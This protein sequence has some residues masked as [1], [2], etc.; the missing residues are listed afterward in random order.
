MNILF[1]KY[2]FLR[3]TLLLLVTSLLSLPAL[4][5]PPVRD[6]LNNPLAQVLVII[7]GVLA[8]AIGILANVVNGAASVFREKMRKEKAEA[9]AAAS[10]PKVLSLL[11][12]GALCIAGSPAMAQQATTSAAPVIN[13]SVNGLTPFS[14]YLLVT[15]IGVEILIM[16]ALTYQLKFLMGLEK[17]RVAKP[18]AEAGPAFSEKLQAFWDKLNQS[19]SMEQEADI[20]LNHDY[21]GIRELDNKVPP[22]WRWVFIFTIVFGA[23]YLW[24]YHV[25]KT[26]PLQNEEFTI[27]MARAELEKAAYLKMAGSKVDESTIVMLDENGV[28][29]GKAIFSQ[30]CIA[31]HGP[32]GQGGTVGPNLADDYWIHGGKISDVFKTIKYGWQE[33]GMRSWKDDFNPEQMAQLSSFV[34]SLKGAKLPNPKEPQGELFVEMA[35]ID[36]SKIAISE[37]PEK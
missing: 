36:S 23:A 6:T 33:K 13:A 19:K 34:K 1:R 30:N 2:H 32:E 4:A 15:V 5:Q 3:K 35:G 16:L 27:D 10:I 14:F 11:I 17:V 9:S 25:G 29:S 21:D 26:A 22:W 8:V 31:C 37:S 24:R 20:D 12:L 28:L 7:I 18:E